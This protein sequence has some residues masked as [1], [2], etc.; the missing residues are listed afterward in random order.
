MGMGANSSS[1]NLDENVPL[2]VSKSTSINNKKK[3]SKKN[4]SINNPGPK[5]IDKKKK[6]L[7]TTVKI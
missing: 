1:E 2:E 6:T 5:L 4:I 3:E 7:R